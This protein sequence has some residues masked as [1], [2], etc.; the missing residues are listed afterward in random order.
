MHDLARC[1]RCARAVP[2]FS[3]W[4]NLGLAVYKLTIGIFGRSAALVAD[5]MHSFTDVVGSSGI[6]VSTRLS[7]KLPD[8]RYPYGRGKA[9]FVGA[10]FV[11]T[12][13]VFFSILIMTGSVRILL[14]HRT[15]RPHFITAF[16]SAV[17][18][19]HN[20]LMYRFETCVGRRTHSPAILADA[21]ENRA[22][23][24]SS[25]AA[26]IGILGALLIHPACDGIAALV[27]ALIIFWNCMVQLREAAV[28]LMDGGLPDEVLEFVRQTALGQAGV[29]GLKFLR[30]RRTGPRYW[31]D[32]GIEVSPDLPV[33]QADLI[34]AA[35]RNRVQRTPQCHHADVYILPAGSAAA[36]P[37]LA[38][39]RQR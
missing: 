2:W 8:A 34:A 4:G 17:S 28:G 9:E 36:V 11:Y 33:E 6:V 39:Q 21:F 35:V 3:F 38:S 13:L 15:E 1:Q 30:S 31:V 14:G 5:A 20:Y 37:P 24:I 26:V 18:V 32:L 29:R 16:G 27:V 22:D 10:V 23:A 7:R 25:V 19:V 12:I